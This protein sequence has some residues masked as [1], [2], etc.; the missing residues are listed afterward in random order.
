VF[1]GYPLVPPGKHEPRP[2]DH[3]EAVEAP[4]LFIAG[5]RDRL[6]PL[7]L[8]EP[9]VDGLARATIDIVA[10]ADHSFRVPKRS[11]IGPDEML[12][13]LAATTVDWIN[14]R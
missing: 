4:M 14:R 6:A 5:T 11:G 3:L 13:R 2:T 12:D 8:L 1:F 9:V 7:S 10:E